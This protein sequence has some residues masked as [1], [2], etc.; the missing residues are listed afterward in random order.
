[1]SILA[2]E[3]LEKTFGPGDLSAA[4]VPAVRGIDLAI[5]QGEFVAITGASGSG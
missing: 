5:R 2:A 1:M 3:N 4:G